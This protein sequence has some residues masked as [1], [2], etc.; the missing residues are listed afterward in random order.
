MLGISGLAS[1]TYEEKC[2]E[3]GIETLAERREIHELLQ[4]YKILNGTGNIDY[5]GLFRKINREAARTRMAAG[6]DNLMTRQARTDIRKNSFSVRVVQKWNA[7]LDE[8]KQS[9]SAEV[10]KNKLKGTVSRKSW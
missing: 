7:L 3:L 4:T 2:K 9:R 10:F 6:H 8:I 5:T 1:N